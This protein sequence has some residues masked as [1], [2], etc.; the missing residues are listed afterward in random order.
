M[1]ARKILVTAALPY[2]NGPLHLG[3]MVEYVLA[4]VFVRSLRM[5]GREVV[6]A[7]ADDT[8][9][10]PIEIAASRAGIKPEELIARFSDEHKK[11][12]S[13]FLI[14]F[15]VFHTTHSPENKTYADFFYNTFKKKG[16]IYERLVEQTYCEKDKRYLP[17]RFVRGICPKC[18]AADQYG[19]QCEKCNST[20]KPIDL[21]EPACS[22]CGSPPV[23]RTS[24]HDFFRLSSFSGELKEWIMGNER[25]QPEIR[26]FVMNWIN[27]GLEDW[28]IT[29]DGPYFGFQVSGKPN[30]YY[31]VWLDAPI[32][33]IS[34]TE[35]YMQQF[36]KTAEE[37][38]KQSGAQIIHF[39]GKD[40]IYFHLLFWPAMLI[41]VGYNLPYDIVVHGFLT[42]NG[43][44][45][46][47]S[48]GNFFTAREYLNSF[49]PEMLRFYYASN[50]SKTS[51]D[52]NLDFKDFQRKINSELVSNIANFIYRTLSFVNNN[53]DSK[54]GRLPK[55]NE[56]KILAARMQSMFD[57][58]MES[59]RNYNLREAVKQLLEIS[60]LGNKY[61]QDNEPWKLI[62]KDKSA[63]HE[64]LSLAANMVRNLSILLYPVMP[65]Y[66]IKIQKQ[67]ALQNLAFSDLGFN[68]ENHKINKARIIYTNIE[69]VPS[70]A[71][72]VF[73]ARLKVAAIT[74]V[75]D[76][77][78][79]DKLYV[80]KVDLG[81]E[82]RTLVAGLRA[83]YPKESLAGRKVI[84]VTNL[85]P[86]KLRGVE[87]QGMLLT[88]DKQGK[89]M[90]LAAP[91]SSPGDGVAA[92]GMDSS[93][94]QIGLDAFHALGLSV[95]GKRVYYKD[96]ILSTKHGSIVVD[97]DDGA[98]IK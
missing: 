20:Y 16:L 5:A 33:Y 56:D 93:E 29:R 17:D 98:G 25:L 38:W 44:K 54:L 78:N 36:H 3:H 1:S 49:D 13:D 90:L 72:E 88:A 31:Y 47:K 9:G 27:S 95:E 43:E 84:V 8:H 96:K 61:L 80:L 57:K 60:S 62:R 74:S 53:F 64:K 10:A 42:V 70:I 91:K 73:P 63:C 30:K 76:H 79:A 89:P 37:Y 86:A 32:G 28:D 23:R 83:F 24:L 39:I 15:D 45:M 46:S 26:N 12:F 87:S 2:A 14:S 68:F 59:Y 18:K 19:D 77:P 58:V 6:F 34:A 48:R 65:D 97:A 55:S 52:V 22:I 4:D 66:C 85:K 92:E 7:C 35:K 81:D 51:S 40:I 94:R 11:D 69:E 21:I 67:L 50:L 82:T 75:D 71:A 41:G